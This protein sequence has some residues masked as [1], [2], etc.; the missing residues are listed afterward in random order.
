MKRVLLLVLLVPGMLFAIK[1]KEANKIRQQMFSDWDQC[2]SL[3]IQ[4]EQIDPAQ[5]LYL[6]LLDYSIEYCRSALSRCDTILNN[7]SGKSKKRK[8]ENWRQQ[9]SKSCQENRK[10]FVK[11]LDELTQI[12]DSIRFQRAITLYEQSVEIAEAAAVLVQ[13]PRRLDNVDEVVSSLE[14]ASKLYSKAA[15]L[16]E[17]AFRWVADSSRDSDKSVL[18]TTISNYN[19]LSEQAFEQAL[20]WPEHVAAQI[21]LSEG[22][23]GDGE[24]CEEY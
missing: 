17:Q 6:E 10:V 22:T 3:V 19:E 18:I 5:D 8:D 9:L 4:I 23:W 20:R 24:P 12:R 11:R 2:N 16:A 7:T 15:G 14:E 13:C 1:E 21:I